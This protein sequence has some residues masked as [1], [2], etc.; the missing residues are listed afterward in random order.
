M[1]AG[2]L[3][4]V[5]GDTKT[6]AAS[7]PMHGGKPSDWGRIALGLVVLQYHRNLFDTGPQKAPE[8]TSHGYDPLVSMF[9]ACEQFAVARAP[10][11]L[12]LPADGR[13]DLRWLFPSQVTRPTPLGGVAIRPGAGNESATGMGVAGVGKRPLAASLPR[14]IFRGE[15]A[16]DWHAC[17][18]GLN[19]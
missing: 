12:G 16:Q 10:P 17:S 14:G 11:D 2:S 15:Q 3:H 4:A 13:E 9:A 18:G 6:G 5:E 1:P 8:L 7:L 19:A